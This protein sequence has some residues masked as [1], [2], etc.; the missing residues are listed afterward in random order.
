MLARTVF[1][2]L[3]GLSVALFSCSKD[4]S[5][6]VAPAGKANQFDDFFDFF[7][8]QQATPAQGDSTAVDT[9][10]KFDIELRFDESV[11]QS[12]RQ[13]FRQG[14]D[15]WEEI[16]LG[17]LPDAI[18]PSQATGSNRY[19]TPYSPHL[20]EAGTTV[21][22]LIVTVTYDDAIIGSAIGAP[23]WIRPET[24][25]PMAGFVV[26]DGEYMA[27]YWRRVGT[28]VDELGQLPAGVDVEEFAQ[29]WLRFW[30]SETAVHEIGH[31]LG[32]GTIWW[33]DDRFHSDDDPMKSYFAGEHA[34][35]AFRAS[36]GFHYEGDV[37]PVYGSGHWNGRLLG[38]AFMDN[39]GYGGIERISTITVGALA[40]LGYE[41]DFSQGHVCTV[42]NPDTFSFSPD[43]RA[44]ASLG[45]LA[46]YEQN[47]DIRRV[48]GEN[49]TRF[50]WWMIQEGH[51]EDGY[52]GIFRG[53]GK[54]VSGL[55]IGA[56]PYSCGVGAP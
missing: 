10:F 29:A 38:E 32:I 22:D 43:R 13:L 54:A 41:V 42:F 21:D 45:E 39:Y 44:V 1:F 52:D 24:R 50:I 4:R 2:L 18:I 37:V 46:L 26:V 31:A 23:T 9:V 36:L 49:Y 8:S 27:E 48:E 15:R 40:D 55:D 5:V 3:L 33:L 35:A 17:D 25:L 53:A 6:P 11:P 30:L 16:I 47:P 34:V 56:M 12:H 51:V 28:T 14:A 19:S 20:V 7:N